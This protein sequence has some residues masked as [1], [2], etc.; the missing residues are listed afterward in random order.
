MERSADSVTR[1][2]AGDQPVRPGAVPVSALHFA[3]NQYY[4][5]MRLVQMYHYSR[6]IPSNVQFVGTLHLSGGLFGDFGDAIAACVFSIPPTRWA[7]DVLEL[8]RLVRHDD[9]KPPL[10]HL[11][12]RA[13]EFLRTMGHDLLVSFADKTHGHE[14][15]VYRA[16]SW[17]LARE[18]SPRM[19]GVMIDG[20][21]V[22]GRT[23]N[24][25]HGTQSPAKLRKIYPDKQIE[26]HY[27]DGKILYW[28]AL[29]RRG[30]KKAQRLGLT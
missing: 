18:N 27:D 7:E 30:L 6:R 4:D 8:A 5:A 3:T 14:G 17:Q 1:C 16:A 22:P 15:Y 20:V 24:S 23:C 19:D 26:P 13:C 29:G 2:T 10:T 21:F 11:I 28:K 25:I 12:S 9:F